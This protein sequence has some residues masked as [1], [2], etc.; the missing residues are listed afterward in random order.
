MMKPEL[1]SKAASALLLMAALLAACAAA[2][3]QQSPPDAAPIYRRAFAEMTKALRDDTDDP[4]DWPRV[5][6]PSIAAYRAARW[7]ERLRATAVARALFTQAAST[8]AR[9]IAAQLE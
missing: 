1:S 8:R 9:R 7:P 6:T 3:A 5:Q 4:V 2:P